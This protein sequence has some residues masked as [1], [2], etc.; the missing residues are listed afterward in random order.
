MTSYALGEQTRVTFPHGGFEVLCFSIVYVNFSSRTIMSTLTPR[1]SQILL[2]KK[3]LNPTLRIR[4]IKLYLKKERKS[5]KKERASQI[6]FHSRLTFAKT[7]IG[8]K[9]RLRF[10]A[11]LIHNISVS[12]DT[13]MNTSS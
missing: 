1:T 4:I 7:S 12:M 3:C 8:L 10:L 13:I 6:T 9:Y 11:K 2:E 5:K